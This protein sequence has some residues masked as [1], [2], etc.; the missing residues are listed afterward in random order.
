MNVPRVDPWTVQIDPAVLTKL[1]SKHGITA[2]EIAEACTMPFKARWDFN[3]EHGRRLIIRGATARGRRLTVM[4]Q[5]VS[6][7]PV[8]W[9]VRTAIVR[10]KD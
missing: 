1:A 5:R 8:V 4:L 7:D 6:Q 3:R 9:V 2:D 10:T